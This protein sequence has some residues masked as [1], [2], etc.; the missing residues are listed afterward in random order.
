MKLLIFSKETVFL[1]VI[2]RSDW[3]NS[4]KPEEKAKLTIESWQKIFD[5]TKQKNDWFING[6]YIQATF[7]ELRKDMV[8]NIKY[9][10]AK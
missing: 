4:L 2:Q 5:V 10:K 8:T 7:W 1:P 3:F 9:F 6:R